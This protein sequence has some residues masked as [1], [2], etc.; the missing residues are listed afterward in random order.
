MHACLAWFV[1]HLN[2]WGLG[3]P[4]FDKQGRGTKPRTTARNICGRVKIDWID[5]YINGTPK[6]PLARIPQLRTHVSGRSYLTLPIGPSGRLSFCNKVRQKNQRARP[7][8]SLSDS[9]LGLQVSSCNKARKG[10]TK[11][12]VHVQIDTDCLNSIKKKCDSRRHPRCKAAGTDR[13]SLRKAMC[14]ADSKSRF[15]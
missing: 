15:K 12:P 4:G 8:T 1:R 3:A 6:R 14:T 10:A 11:G 5:T 7:N 2:E 9:L 13:T